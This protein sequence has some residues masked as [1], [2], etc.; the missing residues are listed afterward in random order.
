MVSNSGR[1]SE[2]WSSITH[3]MK[4]SVTTGHASSISK[5]LA[6]GRPEFE[7]VGVQVVKNVHDV[8]EF[9]MHKLRLL[10]GS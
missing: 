8:E 4:G 7:K 10:N 9:E 3:C 1:P 5:S 6:N 2:N